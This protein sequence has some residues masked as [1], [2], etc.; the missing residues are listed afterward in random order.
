M[1]IR[2]NKLFDGRVL[3]P[4]TDVRIEDGRICELGEAIAPRADE[5]VLDARGG[6]LSPGFID[7][8]IHG[9]HGS[10]TMQA[11]DAVRKMAAWLP[12]HGVTAF[13]PTTMAASLADTKAAL[14]CVAD[15]IDHAPGAR[16]LG[17]HLEGPFLNPARKGAQP[18]PFMLP[19]TRANYDAIVGTHAGAVKLLT[20]APEI[21]GAE[22]L[23]RALAGHVYLA[24]GHTD[25]TYEQLAQA[26]N[27]GVSQVTHLFNGMNPLNHR[28][29]GVPGA[30]LTLPALRVQLI[31][32]LM[33]LHPATL[34]LAW[35]AK[36][37]DGC[38]LITDA[39]EATDLP[40]GEYR[41]GANRV[42][43]EG[44][45][46][47]LKEGNLAGSTL[48]MERAVR[49]MYESVGV[50]LEEALR[51]ATANPAD[52]I[53]RKDLGVIAP[54]ARAD[55]TLLDEQLRVVWTM[56]GGDEVYSCR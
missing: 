55:I 47:R 19:P 53:G 41:L 20:L 24:A 26:V 16:V 8:H 50:P 25:A 44:G 4:N 31:A 17:C 56:V 30:A 11:G 13:A 14:A 34:Q 10:D 29:P 7:L 43:V 46:A 37:P 48:T 3:R 18:G 12:R 45:A 22:V 15:A 21:P 38:I 40:D 32:D 6:L 2:S 28:A 35:R 54:G 51:M 52:A 39:M 27:W 42:F 36:G 1:L 5:P 49:N 9:I 23:I 33:H